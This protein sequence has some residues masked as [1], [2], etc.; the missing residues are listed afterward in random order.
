[1]T[2]A[3]ARHDHSL[4]L[5]PDAQAGV[6]PIGVVDTNKRDGDRERLLCVT[7]CA[8]KGIMLARLVDR[9]ANRFA[10]VLS[11]GPARFATC[12][13]CGTSLLLASLP[14]SGQRLAAVV[15]AHMALADAW[16]AGVS[17]VL[18]VEQERA[19]AGHHRTC[20]CSVCRR[21]RGTLA[22][23]GAALD[24]LALVRQHWLAQVAQRAP[25]AQT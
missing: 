7:C 11:D 8:R 24:G 6:A 9:P 21:W 23:V 22:A 25:E 10:V 19:A 3:S 17:S 2:T 14:A 4:L 20:G 5:P 16:E 18:A 13:A 1:M 15:S 12:S